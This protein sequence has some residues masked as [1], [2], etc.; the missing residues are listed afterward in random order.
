MV[1]F[2][3]LLVQPA[4]GVSGPWKDRADWFTSLQGSEQWWGTDSLLTLGG[5][6]GDW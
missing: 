4:A 2:W 6:G 1:P 3:M 5:A